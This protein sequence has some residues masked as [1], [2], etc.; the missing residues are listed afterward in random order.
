[1]SNMR[2]ILA[3]FDSASTPVA[4]CGMGEGGMEPQG[5]ITLT[6]SNAEQM[7]ELLKALSGVDNKPAEPLTAIP[8]D[9]PDEPGRDD[10]EGDDD[11]ESGML[12]QMAGGALG[13]MAGAALG[14]PVGGAV[15]GAA[16][17]AIGDKLTGEDY[18]NEPEEEYGDMD[19]VLP[20]GDDMHRKKDS[21]AV[22]VKDP[23]VE[24]TIKDRLWAA[25]NEMKEGTCNECGNAMLTA[26]EKKEL[27]DLEEGKKHGNS[28]IYDKCWKG[29]TKVAGKKRGE[30]GS[31]KCD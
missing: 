1:M 26:S 21:K 10:V 19:D 15:G 30:P 18:D 4:E 7:A 14:G 22:R 20:S 2:D 24:T 5:G 16:G 17:S 28:K 23:A 13:T 3:K 9:D 27:A 8:V 31:C 11:I 6:T 29:C 12:G 25:L